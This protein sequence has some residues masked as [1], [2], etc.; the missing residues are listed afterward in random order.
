M[1]CDTQNAD[2]REATC[3]NSGVSADTAGDCAVLAAIAQNLGEQPSLF[4]ALEEI[5]PHFDELPE[6]A[7]EAVRCR[8][9]VGQYASLAAL[10]LHWDDLYSVFPP[11]EQYELGQQMVEAASDR[12]FA[13]WV[14][15]NV[16]PDEYADFLKPLQQVAE[17][18]G[19][20]LPESPYAQWA[21]YRDTLSKHTP[22]AQ[23]KKIETAAEVVNT[24]IH[25]VVS[26]IGM[27]ACNMFLAPSEDDIQLPNGY[28]ADTI[29]LGGVILT[30]VELPGDSTEIE[31]YVADTAEGAYEQ[32]TDICNY[33]GG[34][35]EQ[36]VGRLE[37][38]GAET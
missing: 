15:Q 14:T 24:R 8:I 23:K 29:K 3:A 36:F 31:M 37:E 12:G 6:Q 1:S 7:R 16:Y 11:E 25:A 21:A 32:Y 19:C 38:R 10:A 27:L 2:S 20:S 22:P 17:E 28:R 5:A 33:A 4:A 9:L 26:E 30:R 35:P 13:D 18:Q 34:S